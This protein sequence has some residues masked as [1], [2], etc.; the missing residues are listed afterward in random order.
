MPT[1]T[2][3]AGRTRTPLPVDT[4]NPDAPVVMADKVR[5][6]L[7]DPPEEGNSVEDFLAANVAQLQNL[8]L[9]LGINTRKVSGVSFTDGPDVAAV[10][11]DDIRV[12]YL[13]S[14]DGR[15]PSLETDWDAFKF[16]LAS[17]SRTI[18]EH[19]HLLI[20][21]SYDPDTINV[22]EW[23]VRIGDTLLTGNHFITDETSTVTQNLPTGWVV[24]VYTSTRD[25]ADL[26]TVGRNTPI[27]LVRHNTVPTWG[28]ALGDGVVDLDALADAVAARLLPAVIG[29][30]G[31]HV[32]VNSAGTGVEWFTPS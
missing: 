23:T 10:A 24:R 20:F 26:L 9:L 27:T 19:T 18:S 15:F 29:T 13:G 12:G 8:L 7:A 22:N 32:R 3:P 25:G 1:L 5:A 17:P 14:A 31:Q 6:G 30:A 28:G 2:N 21:L 16:A 11:G 4:T